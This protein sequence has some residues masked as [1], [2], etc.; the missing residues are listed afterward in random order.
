MMGTVV[1]WKK[2][3]P[4][5]VPN[6]DVFAKLPNGIL[7]PSSSS[8]LSSLWQKRFG[9]NASPKALHSMQQEDEGILLQSFW[10]FCTTSKTFFTPFSA[11]EVQKLLMLIVHLWPRMHRWRHRAIYALPLLLATTYLHSSWRK[12]ARFYYL[13]RRVASIYLW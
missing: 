1:K 3:L 9:I 6:G 13:N 10:S 8:S 5:R 2:L 11:S 7:L 12:L 4:C